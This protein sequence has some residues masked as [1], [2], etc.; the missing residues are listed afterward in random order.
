MMQILQQLA[1]FTG[2]SFI[3]ACG[4]SSQPDIIYDTTGAAFDYSYQA[5]I[6]SVTAR[7]GS[8]PPTRCGGQEI[9][10]LTTGRFIELC[11]ATR[12]NAP[13]VY[14]STFDE[15]CRLVACQ[16]GRDCPQ[17]E[18]QAYECRHG[19]CQTPGTA[20]TA[21]DRATAVFLCAGSLPRPLV[22]MEPDALSAWQTIS[23][24]VLS[25]CPIRGEPCV[26]PAD[27]LQ[28]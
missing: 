24:H 18:D 13:G 5:G 6:S 20:S 3:A 17:F 26:P 19:L 22:C 14:W 12:E 27:C 1:V 4:I 9:F 23:M 25:S 8:P 10:A 15:Q 2:L 7:M 21:V 16:S 11:A 28:P